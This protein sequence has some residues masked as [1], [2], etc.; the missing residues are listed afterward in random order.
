MQEE[1]ATDDSYWICPLFAFEYVDDSSEYIDLGEG[2]SIWRIPGKLL[3]SILRRRPELELDISGVEWAIQIYEKRK[4]G[5]T[6]VIPWENLIDVL[7]AIRLQ[8]KGDVIPGA[9]LDIQTVDDGFTAGGTTS[10]SKL[11]KAGSYSF[12]VPP[13]IQYRLLEEEVEALKEFWQDF[14]N[15]KKAGKINGLEVAISRFNSSY[16]ENLADRLLDQMIA[17]E[18]LYL[19]DTKELGY[20]LALRAAFLLE[21]KGDKRK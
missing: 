9:L 8:H 12:R 7:T 3:D 1:R 13:T 19:G 18:S 2:I 5:T 17:L 21:T 6:M 15:T 11:S 10:R 16:G 4:I 14:R 20:K